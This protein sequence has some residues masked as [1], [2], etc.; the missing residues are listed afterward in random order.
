MR[1]SVG[2]ACLSAFALLLA[3]CRLDMHL[4]PKYLP[5]E[6]TDFFADG[7]SERQPVP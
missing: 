1:R 3:G 4:Q 5:Y 6:A 7:R 2:L